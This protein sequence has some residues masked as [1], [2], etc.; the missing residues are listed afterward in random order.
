MITND[1][2]AAA[3]IER[4]T[5][6]YD[7]KKALQSSAKVRINEKTGKRYLIIPFFH[8]KT[9]LTKA[10][11]SAGELRSMN[12]STFRRGDFPSGSVAHMRAI[13]KGTPE[14]PHSYDW[15]ESPNRVEDTG[16]V[17]MH[18]PG[19]HFHVTGG[20]LKGRTVTPH[21]KSSPFERTYKFKMKGGGSRFT[22]FRTMSESQDD[23]EWI[24]PGL[25]AHRLAENAANSVRGY[26]NERIGKLSSE[27]LDQLEKML[28]HQN[29]SE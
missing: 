13:R 11:I 25:Y 9:A 19:Y 27:L 7:L 16:K 28:N 12:P 3:Y 14:K 8:S 20:S 22:S 17:G 2:P 24:H 6:P 23:N 26:M 21:W 5:K 15:G 1:H 4:G 18:V 29:V 10:G